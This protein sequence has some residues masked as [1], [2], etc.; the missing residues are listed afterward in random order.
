MEDNCLNLHLLPPNNV[1]VWRRRRKE[2]GWTIAAPARTRMMVAVV[3][4][5]GKRRRR[6]DE[7]G[8]RDR[9]KNCSSHPEGSHKYCM[10]DDDRHYLS[11]TFPDQNRRGEQFHSWPMFRPATPGGRTSLSPELAALCSNSLPPSLLLLLVSFCILNVPFHCAPLPID[12]ARHVGKKKK[13]EG[14]SHSDELNSGPW[15]DEARRKWT[16]CNMVINC[17]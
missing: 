15:K 14:E 5:F 13:K 12:R 3:G 17:T 8:G 11:W 4:R 10:P 2:A 9:Y 1:Q 16:R 6:G 7:G